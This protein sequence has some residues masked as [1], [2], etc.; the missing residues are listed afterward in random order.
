MLLLPWLG[1]ALQDSYDGCHYKGPNHIRCLETSEA[2]GIY[3]P[4]TDRMASVALIL[5][6]TFERNISLKGEAYISFKG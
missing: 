1:E 6:E 4:K 5:H 3:N 2:G